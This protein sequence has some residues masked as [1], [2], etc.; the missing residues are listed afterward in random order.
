MSKW[1]LTYKGTEILT[2]EEWNRVVDALEELDGRSPARV[3][4]GVATFSGDG[5]TTAF[6]IAHGLGAA[7]TA[8]LVGKAASGL[9]DIDYWEADATYIVVHFKSAPPAGAE[10]RI[11][12]L[13]VR[14]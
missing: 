2:P 1:G 5:A 8:A 13:A 12:W 6:S 14:L 10:V 11:W 7:P 4:A 9:P 3:R